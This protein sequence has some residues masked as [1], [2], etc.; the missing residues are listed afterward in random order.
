MALEP[1]NIQSDL[2]LGKLQ[3]EVHAWNVNQRGRYLNELTNMAQLNEE[4]GD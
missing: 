1:L 2:P 3:D 4:V